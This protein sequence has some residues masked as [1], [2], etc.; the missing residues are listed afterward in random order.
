MRVHWRVLSSGAQAT[1]PSDDGGAEL[2]LACVLPLPQEVSALAFHPWPQAAPGADF[3]GGHAAAGPGGHPP[4]GALGG[5][6]GAERGA[7][8]PPPH[9]TLVCGFG[10]GSSQ[11][12]SYELL[13]EG[14]G[15]GGG[16]GGHLRGSEAEGGRFEHGSGGTS[17]LSFSPD[18]ALLVSAG[19]RRVM[20]HD[21]G[22][23]VAA[24]QVNELHTRAITFSRDGALL[25]SVGP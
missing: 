3:L 20:L 23:H 22:A 19:S 2:L 18:G 13:P 14:G 4:G 9:E 1:E 21:F 7:G 6:G 10:S 16:G 5:G 15:V 25:A 11:L 12:L 8:A 24:L 17:A